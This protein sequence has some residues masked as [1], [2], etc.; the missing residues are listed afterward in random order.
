MIASAEATSPKFSLKECAAVN[1]M[2]IHAM[3]WH[4]PSMGK[5]IARVV[6][7]AWLG[8]GM[9]LGVLLRPAINEL[10]L[11]GGESV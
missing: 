8:L 3:L 5:A 1:G 6:G 10:T 7:R 2:E 9:M 4:I 11:A